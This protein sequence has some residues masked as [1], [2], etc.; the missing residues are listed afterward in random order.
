MRCFLYLMPS[1]PAAGSAENSLAID[2]FHSRIVCLTE[3]AYREVRNLL[4]CAKGRIYKIS[5]YCSQNA[6][7]ALHLSQIRTH[8][9]PSSLCFR[10]LYLPKRSGVQPKVA[11]IASHSLQY[12]TTLPTRRENRGLV[13]EI[14]LSI[15]KKTIRLSVNSLAVS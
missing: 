4:D 9:I 6:W 10:N 7:Y 15:D 14:I 5:L 2:P 11:S 1:I 13:P 12:I 8:Y 3:P